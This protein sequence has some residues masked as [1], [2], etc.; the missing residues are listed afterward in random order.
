V[1]FAAA[2][3][4][5][6]STAYERATAYIAVHRALGENPVPYFHEVE[7]IMLEHGG[8]PHWGKMHWQEATDLAERYPRFHDFT[9][10]WARL[11]PDGVFLNTHLERVLTGEQRAASTAC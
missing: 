6:L 9:A 4:L 8:R 5:W 3:P 7:R 1:R 10:V 11:D 2:D